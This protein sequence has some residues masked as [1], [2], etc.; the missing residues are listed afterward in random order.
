MDAST[1]DSIRIRGHGMTA[2]A[3]DEMLGYPELQQHVESDQGGL[4]GRVGADRKLE[5]ESGTWPK[6]LDRAGKFAREM[7]LRCPRV[8]ATERYDDKS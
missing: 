7:R 4:L 6:V 2:K 1:E 3:Y 8:R 5:I